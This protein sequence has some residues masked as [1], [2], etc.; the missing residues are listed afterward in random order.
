M[1][2]EHF[3]LN[4]SK[5]IIQIGQQ[6]RKMSSIYLLKLDH[7]YNKIWLT[8]TK[9]IDKC[10]NLLKSEIKYLNINIENFDNV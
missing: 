1:S 7:T 6:L 10:L 8:G 9:N 5:K 4:N 2:L 3:K